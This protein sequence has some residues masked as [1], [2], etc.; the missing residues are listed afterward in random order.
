MI[1]ELF[2]GTNLKGKMIIG[3]I[4]ICVGLVGFSMFKPW[5][6]VPAGHRGVEMHF[7]AVQN[8][9]LGEGIH[10]RLPIRDSFEMI[11]IR[12]QKVEAICT[13]ASKD[14]QKAHSKIAVVYKIDPATVNKLYKEVG[15][16]YNDKI[17][18]PAIQEC[19]KASTAKYSAEDLVLK[20][21]IV[22]QEMK[23]LLQ[24]KLNAYKMVITMFNVTDFDFSD[25]FNEAIEAKQTAQQNALTANNDLERIKA[26]AKQKVEQARAE[27]ESLR[28]QKEQITPT[29]LEL[30]KIEA[31]QE[32][33]KAWEK[34]GS[35]VPQYMMGDNGVMPMM[36]VK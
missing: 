29:L 22:S 34:G 8:N 11:E 18:S 9:V 2:E 26:E 13:A 33:I 10:L 21:E 1:R 17:V 27:A 3:G 6:S 24:S 4:V 19:V 23:N 32:W 5:V 28:L 12:E 15:L 35:K 36:Q 25:G 14:V 16:S 20:R 31:Q 7:G 30:R